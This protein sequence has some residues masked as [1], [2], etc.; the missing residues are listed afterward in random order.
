LVRRTEQFGIF[1]SVVK[2]NR[3]VRIGCPS[4]LDAS[5]RTLMHLTRDSV[6]PQSFVNEAQTFGV[7]PGGF[8]GF[9]DNASYVKLDGWTHAKTLFFRRSLRHI[10]GPGY[11]HVPSKSIGTMN[12]PLLRLY[13]PADWDD[14]IRLEIETSLASMGDASDEAKERFR[15]EWPDTLRS[16]YGWTDSGP[17]ALESK[18]WVLHS[19]EGTFAGMVWLTEQTDFFT[20]ERDV[21]ITTVALTEAFRGRGWGRLL[22]EHALQVAK[23]IGVSSVG[24]GVASSNLA[25]IRLYEKLGFRTTRMSMQ[26]KVQ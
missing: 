1:N 19:V 13:R 2:V 20:G 7:F 21:F 9:A 18:L 15:S 8:A 5:H 10:F 11:D 14:V 12:A 22:M 6:V 4:S 26:A 25:A 24:L 17:T 23:D 3:V 16:R